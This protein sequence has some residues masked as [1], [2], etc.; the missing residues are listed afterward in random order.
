MIALLSGE[1]S[2]CISIAIFFEL[3]WLDFFPAGTFIPPNHAFIT[4]LCLVVSQT[5]GLK[6]PVQI[7]P[8]II[9]CLPLSWVGTKIELKYRLWQNTIHDKL[10]QDS[11]NDL[12]H[13]QTDKLVKQALIHI[14]LINSFLFII[15]S[16][17][18][19]YIMSFILIHWPNEIKN[20]TWAHLWSAALIGGIL[21][22]RIR[23]AYELLIV[24]AFIM[25]VLMRIL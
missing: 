7:L 23:R 2:I 21:S 25:I 22:L 24:G 16:L 12:Q 17:L 1:W 3:L 15:S 13:I 20:L 19:Y 6:S 8:V 10:L 4:F 18:I 11:N 14:T 9:I 5:L